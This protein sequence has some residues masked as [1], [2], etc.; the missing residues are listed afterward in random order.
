MAPSSWAARK[1]DI[2]SANAG[3]FIGRLNQNGADLG[4]ALGLSPDA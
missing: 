2:T 4:S 3:G 1:V